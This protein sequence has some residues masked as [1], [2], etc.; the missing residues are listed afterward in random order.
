[1]CQGRVRRFAACAYCGDRFELGGEQHPFLCNDCG[2]RL[3]SVTPKRYWRH[4]P[5]PHAPACGCP[6][7]QEERGV[8]AVLAVAEG[9]D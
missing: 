4:T 7:C 1:M 9:A 3:F 5:A 2:N 8:P 6:R